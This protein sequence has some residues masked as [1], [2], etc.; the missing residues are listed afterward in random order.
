MVI[1]VRSSSE[2]V[3]R[4]PPCRTATTARVARAAWLITIAACAAIARGAVAQLA[5][6]QDPVDD[7]HRDQEN[8]DPGHDRGGEGMA[9]PPAAHRPIIEVE[10]RQDEGDERD[11]QRRAPRFRP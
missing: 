6:R 5:H 3:S 2:A 8:E 1:Y 10:D 4:S 11:G 9:P 7:Q